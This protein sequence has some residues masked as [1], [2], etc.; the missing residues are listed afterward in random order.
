MNQPMSIN[1]NQGANITLQD[2]SEALTYSVEAFTSPEYAK[3]EADQLWAKVWQMA[4]RVEELPAVGSFITYQIGDESILIV[5]SA[6]DALKAYFN[7]CPHRGRRLV[8]TPPG[9]N[10]ACGKQQRFVCG[11]HGWS[12]NLQGKN[13]F[14]LD[15]QDWKGALTEERAHQSGGAGGSWGGGVVKKN[16]T[17]RP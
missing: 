12:F 13:V 8:D 10:R 4:G 16:V 7:V 15:P 14:V 3:A 11:F 5:R 9:E 17:P 2:L 6:P 1:A